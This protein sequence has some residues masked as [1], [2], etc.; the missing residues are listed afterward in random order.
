M[1]TTKARK[2]KSAAAVAWT[3]L[4]C[5]LGCGEMP[6]NVG[7]MGRFKFVC[8]TYQARSPKTTA[9]CDGG[10]MRPMWHQRCIAVDEWNET[11]QHNAKVS[12]GK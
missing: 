9:R 7:N 3:D 2:R 12:G 4:L 1:K 8:R 11:Q 10:Q 6:I 5:C